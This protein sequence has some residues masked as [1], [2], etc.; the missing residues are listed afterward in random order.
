MPKAWRYIVDGQDN[1]VLKLE[2]EHVSVLEKVKGFCEKIESEEYNVIIDSF[3]DPEITTES[4][5]E[6]AKKILREV[7]DLLR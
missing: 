4:G 3:A 6:E 7:E 5:R 2:S 1:I